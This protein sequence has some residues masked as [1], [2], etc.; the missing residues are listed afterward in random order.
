MSTETPP[1]VIK[2]N[3]SSCGGERNCE[4]RGYH[5]QR[6][7]DDYRH[8]SKK[9]YILECRGCEHVFA[10]TSFSR[11]EDFEV[12]YL[13]NGEEILDH[14]VYNDTWPAQLKRNRPDWF[15]NVLLIGGDLSEALTELYGALDNDLNT[16]AAIGMRTTFDV[17]SGRLGVS[18]NM[19]FKEKLGELAHKGHIGVIDE[20]RL[21]A[22]VEAGNASA[23]RGWKPSGHDLNTMMDVLEHFLHEAFVRP[24]LNSHLDA[25]IDKMK[26]LVPP[27]ATIKFPATPPLSVPDAN[28]PAPSTLPPILP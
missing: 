27:R 19:T 1:T 18:Q 21:L 23:H 3:C 24:A 12:V 11:S 10:Q 20:K 8:W 14:N 9:W 26:S 6:G 15:A 25:K 17:A 13:P 22:L 16:L 28:P 7:D 2:A 4:V 5:D